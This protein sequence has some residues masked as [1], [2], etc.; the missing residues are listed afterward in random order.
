MFCFLLGLQVKSQAILRLCVFY[1]VDGVFMK[2]A[3]VAENVKRLVEKLP[4]QETFIYE[5][6]L[7]YGT[8]KA[9]IARLKSG[10]LNLTKEPGE[11]LLKKKVWFKNVA[12]AS[13]LPDPE[14]PNDNK[15]AGRLL[16]DLDKIRDGLRAAH[17]NLDLAVDR[18]YRTKPF[19]SDEERLEHL[20]KLYE[21]MVAKEQLV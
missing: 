18:L 15:Q 9:T 20:F 21:E 10:Q 7:A 8:P 17:H 3:E 14:E 12:Q 16:Y 5:L 6:L 2:Y 1:W 13:R 11:V 4:P 19:A